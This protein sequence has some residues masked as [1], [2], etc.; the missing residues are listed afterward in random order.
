MTFALGRIRAFPSPLAALNAK[1]RSPVNAI[2][3]GTVISLA[4]M[5]PLGI[6]YTPEVAFAMVGTAQTILIVGV[7][8]L[9][10]ASCIGFYS[11][12]RDHKLN[13][14]SHV[15]IPVLGIAAFIPAWF[16]GVGI[17]ILGLKFITPLVKPYSY[18]GPAVAVWMGLGVVFLIVLYIVNPRRVTEVGLVHID[19]PADERVSA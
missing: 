1:H 6:H 9:M 2:A 16:D 10:N 15:I 3:L 18:M 19:A 8:I 11:R 5:L 17:K 7:Y 14:L 4:V 13:L 12:S